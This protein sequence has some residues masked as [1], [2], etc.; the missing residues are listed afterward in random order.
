[1]RDSQDEQHHGKGNMNQEPGVEDL[2]KLLLT[3]KLA[4]LI[5]ISFQPGQK[6][7]EV[8]SPL[9]FGGLGENFPGNRSMGNGTVDGQDLT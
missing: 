4:A 6:G 2:V 3:G 1:M 8:W 9:D 7:H 5:A